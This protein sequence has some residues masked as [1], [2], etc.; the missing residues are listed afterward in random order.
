MAFSKHIVVVLFVIPVFVGCSATI[1]DA[2]ITEEMRVHGKAL[3]EAPIPENKALIELATNVAIPVDL[4]QNENGVACSP[5]NKNWIGRASVAKAYD[6]ERPIDEDSLTGNFR[7]FK[8]SG[9]KLIPHLIAPERSFF[10]VDAGVES[11][12]R[13]SALLGV[14]SG[15][16]SKTLSCGPLFFGFTPKAGSRYRYTFVGEGKYCRSLLQEIGDAGDQSHATY[17]TWTC[18]RDMQEAPPKV[19]ALE[20]LPQ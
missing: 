20:V 11:V 8:G 6:P 5:G 7:W 3:S 13:S 14:G 10:Y 4:R 17:T 2:P 16:H 1:I 12:F 18:N 15:N 19:N 9:G